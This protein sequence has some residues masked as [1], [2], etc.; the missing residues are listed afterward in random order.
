MTTMAPMKVAFW[1]N[2]NSIQAE[3]SKVLFLTGLSITRKL[4]NLV[5]CN[6]KNKNKNV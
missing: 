3:I 4:F 2:K 6:P 1:A 5:E